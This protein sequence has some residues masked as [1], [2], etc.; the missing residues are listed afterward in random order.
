MSLTYTTLISSLSNLIAISSSDTNF[1]GILPEV[2]DYAELRIQR[3]LDFLNSV[4]TD[5]TI[6]TVSGTRQITAPSTFVVIEQINMITPAGTTLPDSGT[7]V[8]CVP[9]TKEYLDYVWNS[10]TTTSVPTFFAMLN[11]LTMILGP[12]PDDEYT[13]EIVGTQREVPL[14]S[15]NA[16]NYMSVYLPDVY[17][18]AAMI[19][20]SGWMRNFGSQADN[21]QMAMSWET[22]YNNLLKSATVE[23]FRKKFAGSAWSSMS[24]PA[25]ATPTR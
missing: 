16:T 3:D 24:P 14:S 9:V 5:T 23:E 10:S 25:I 15:T 20:V 8:Q 2:I 22:Q 6:T 4:T 21:P 18:A 13:V 17:L 12:F 1:I 19:F 11:N 7:R